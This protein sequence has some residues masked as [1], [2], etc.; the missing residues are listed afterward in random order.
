MARETGWPAADLAPSAALSLSGVIARI[1]EE[2]GAL[3]RELDE[4]AMLVGQATEETERHEGRR[5]RGEE[6]LR[7]LEKEPRSDP[8]ELTEARTQLIALT[9]RQMLFDAQREVLA[10]KQKTLARY[11]EGLARVLA[12]LSELDPALTATGEGPGGRTDRPNAVSAM[13]LRAEE[14]LRRDIARQMHDGPAQSLANIALQSEIVER[15]VARG[16]QRAT[17]ELGALRRMVQSTLTAT[18]EFIFDVRPM[19]L[20]DLGLVPTLRRTALDRGS[21]AGLEVDFDSSGADR[22][23]GSDLESGLFRILDDLIAGYVQLRPER[24]TVRLDWSPREL[25]AMVR[26]H[27]QARQSAKQT[28]EQPRDL[29]P[30]LAAMME[31]KDTEERQA[32]IDARSLPASRSAEIRNHAAILGISMTVLDSG[33]ATE[34]VTPLP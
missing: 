9:R 18:K 30:A 19:V 3:G 34:I 28:P 6:R 8:A 32:A 12:E 10:G 24:V 2:L 31:Q 26:G 4:I 17:A 5:Q 27:W 14:D 13:V 33:E 29:P 23:L 1:T 21:R 22:R 7:A 25:S 16:D 11:Q 15:L 20:D